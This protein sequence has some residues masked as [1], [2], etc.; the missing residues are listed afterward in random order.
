[1]VVGV[2]HRDQRHRA[3]S[4]QSR[5]GCLAL[6]ARAAPAASLD[7]F[8]Q[9]Q[10]DTSRTFARATLYVWVALGKRKRKS[11]GT[12]PRWLAEPSGA[13]SEN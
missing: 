1:M 10:S 7:D 4:A 8:A 3:S 13:S 5:S 9:E 12:H 6:L 11:Y 2:S